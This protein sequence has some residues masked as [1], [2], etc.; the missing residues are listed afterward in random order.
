MKELIPQDEYG[1]F[2][3]M[4]DTPRCTSLKVA[5][6]FGKRHNDV[7]RAIER[8]D[9]SDEFNQRNFALVKYKDAKGESRPMYT[10]TR[11]GFTFL[12]MGFHGIKAAYFKEQYITRFNE[13]EKFIFTLVDARDQFPLLT[14]NI[15]LMYDNPR[16]Y[17]FSNE[18]DMINR[19]VIGMTAKQFRESHGLQNGQSIRPLLSKEQLDKLDTL[20]KIDIGLLVSTPDYGQRK[21]YL[22]WYMAKALTA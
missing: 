10:M 17:H 2:A 3:D 11:D 13:M 19:I 8:L 1:V 6:Y 4:K 16:P 20:Q 15:K 18:C 7:L 21:R 9:C 12:A 14:A 22:E 5:E